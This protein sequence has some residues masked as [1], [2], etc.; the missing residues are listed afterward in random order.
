MS[1]P[2][3]DHIAEPIRSLAID[4]EPLVH[5]PR[6]ARRH[7]QRNIE[8]IQASLEKFGQLKPIVLADDGVTILAGNGTVH[9]GRQLGWTH[10][11]A[12]TSGFSPD[13]PQAKAF[14]IADNRSAELALWDDERLAQTLSELQAEDFDVGQLGFT[15]KEI[16]E[17]IDDGPVMVPDQ[18]VGNGHATDGKTS[19]EEDSPGFGRPLS[20]TIEQREI[21]DQVIAKIR[22]REHE[23]LSEGRCIELALADWNAGN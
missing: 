22:E 11:A 21:V 10:V 19:Q 5:D 14:A 3:L 13:S 7:D 1:E 18:P 12:V 17:L 20:L 4:I 23:D 9:A 15:D 16:A 8:A 2:N 6:N